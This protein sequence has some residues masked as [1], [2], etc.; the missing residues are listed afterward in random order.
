MQMLETKNR[1]LQKRLQKRLQE[2]KP[3]TDTPYFWRVI[4]GA[5]T[6]GPDGDTSQ[7]NPGPASEYYPEFDSDAHGEQQQNLVTD[8]YTS[9]INP[10]PDSEYYH[11]EGDQ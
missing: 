9:H 8:D 11:P 4:E 1:Q 10:G 3:D 2:A 5:K 6:A 7:R